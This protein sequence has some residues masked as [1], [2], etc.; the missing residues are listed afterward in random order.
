MV[1]SIASIVFGCP[2]EA[3][4]GRGATRSE[5]HK[6]PPTWGVGTKHSA[7]LVP[8]AFN[9]HYFRLESTARASEHILSIIQLG[10]ISPR[11]L[12]R[13]ERH[14]AAAETIRADYDL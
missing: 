9:A 3:E 2:K 11:T 7:A 6:T 10:G 8:R 4:L 5:E 1:V 13:F 14:P 12:P